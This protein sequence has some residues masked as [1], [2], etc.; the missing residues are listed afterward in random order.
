MFLY[1]DG[2]MGIEWLK[3]GL[4]YFMTRNIS[5]VFLIEHLI[6]L[7]AIDHYK[8]HNGR[9]HKMS[10]IVICSN[11]ICQFESGLLNRIQYLSILLYHRT[12]HIIVYTLGIFY[13]SFK[14]AWLSELE[15]CHLPV[16]CGTLHVC[17]PVPNPYIFSIVY[18]ALNKFA[19]TPNH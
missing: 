12:V 1:T 4:V 3:L 5:P 10:D 14:S 8:K 16:L 11:Y 17:V 19:V 18:L 13:N 2:V 6:L 7:N 15:R 9:C